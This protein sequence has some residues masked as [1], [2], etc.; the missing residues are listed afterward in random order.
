M[1]NT[2]M[3]RRPSAEIET[4]QPDIVGE[5]FAAHGEDIRT[6][7]AD[8]VSVDQ[9]RLGVVRALQKS[10]D[11]R[12]ADPA[13][14]VGAIMD[15]ARLGLI[16]AGYD[17]QAAIITRAGQAALMVMVGGLLDLARREGVLD[18]C[19]ETVR[20]GE[21]MSYDPHAGT[22]AHTIT[23]PRPPKV[24]AAYAWAVLAGGARTGV[25]V[26][27]A[28]EIAAARAAGSGGGAWKSWEGEM[29]KKVAKRR[30]IRARRLLSPTAALHLTTV[31]G[32]DDAP[33]EETQSPT[34]ANV[35]AEVM[36]RTPASLPAPEARPAD[37]A[38][39]ADVAR[40]IDALAAAEDARVSR[41][42]ASTNAAVTAVG[43]SLGA[44]VKS[45][46]PDTTDMRVIVT[47]LRAE[48]A[49]LVRTE[50]ETA[51]AAM[52]RAT[53]ALGPVAARNFQEW[54]REA[55]AAIAALRMDLEQGAEPGADG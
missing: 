32:D 16:P 44:T 8:R 14:L 30:L 40:G 4:R 24:I 34:A 18:V 10:P 49:Q 39:M 6:A 22:V 36:A 26:V 43:Q 7:L 38:T 5:L 42:Q 46:G 53:E 17:A 13:S 11:L 54:R 21:A 52:A 2:Q 12:R 48:Y 45:V 28:A 55:E 47:K 33:D 51:A 23:M 35:R 15:C 9:F 29:A 1:S 27:T 19:A 3:T 37:G 25:E 41:L 20:E 31:E 50:D